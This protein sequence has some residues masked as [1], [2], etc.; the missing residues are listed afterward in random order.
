M[1]NPDVVRALEEDVI[2]G[3]LAPG[4]RLVE[5][6][7][8][9]R[10][11]ATRH[12]VRAALHELELMGVIV[13]EKNRGAAVRSLNSAE[14]EQ[15]YDVREFLQRQAALRIPLPAPVELMRKL[16]AIQAGYARSIAEGNFRR[17]HELNDEFHLT[18]FAGC[19]N[20]YLVD[21]IRFYMKLSLL[22]RAKTMADAPMLDLSRRQHEQIIAL[23]EGTDPWALAQL[24]A[25]HI[26]P[27]KRAYLHQVGPGE[28]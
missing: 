22:V 12:F 3:R 26:Q 15:I 8:M 14:V 16:R 7:L 10:F 5:D 17:V 23:L 27:A 6:T 19:G 9:A 25:E 18:L 21:S 1:D 2:F 13:R 20:A 4:A 24:C 28:G 11:G